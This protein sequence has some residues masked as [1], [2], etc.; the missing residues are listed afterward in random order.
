ML[1]FKPGIVYP[2]HYPGQNGLSDVNSF[3]EIVQKANP[4]IEVRLRN[5]YSAAQ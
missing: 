3:Q 4:N 1:A 2:Y 5:W